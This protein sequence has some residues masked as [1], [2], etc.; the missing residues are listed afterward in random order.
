[1]EEN[2]IDLKN[3][4]KIDKTDEYKLGLTFKFSQFMGLIVWKAR[5]PRMVLSI[6]WKLG[7]ERWSMQKKACYHGFHNKH[8]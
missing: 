2:F 3:V 7:C 4:P 5:G 6:G 1:M 8:G